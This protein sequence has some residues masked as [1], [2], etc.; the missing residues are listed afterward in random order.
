MQTSVAGCPFKGGKSPLVDCL[1]GL[2]TL[3]NALEV[4]AVADFPKSFLLDPVLAALSQ[5]LAHMGVRSTDELGSV[6]HFC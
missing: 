5:H 2:F 4:G 1:Q 3:V 6:A